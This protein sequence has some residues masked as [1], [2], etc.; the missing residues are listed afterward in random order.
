MSEEELSKEPPADAPDELV[1]KELTIHDS[2]NESS[3]KPDS[4]SQHMREEN[5]TKWC[6]EYD[7][8]SGT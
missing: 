4:E 3:T 1:Q 7:A 6:L 2:D 5:R 8:G